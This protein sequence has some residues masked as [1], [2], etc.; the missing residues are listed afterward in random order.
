MKKKGRKKLNDININHIHSLD[1]L[2]SMCFTRRKKKLKTY[3]IMI[4]S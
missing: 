2:N 1:E 3:K 4:E